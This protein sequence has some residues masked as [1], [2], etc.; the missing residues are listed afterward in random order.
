MNVPGVTSLSVDLHKYG[1]AAKGASIIL[2]ANK[3]LRKYQF[4]A[5]SRWSEISGALRARSVVFGREKVA[6][7]S[8]GEYYRFDISG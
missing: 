1:Y 4:W 7:E 6:D 2:Y 3:E 5:C 8:N